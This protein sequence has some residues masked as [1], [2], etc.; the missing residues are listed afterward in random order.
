MFPGEY[1]SNLTRKTFVQVPVISGY[2]T[3]RLQAQDYFPAPISGTLTSM[4]VTLE[5]TGR[6]QTSVLLRETSDRSISGTRYTVMPAVT[7]VPGGK[8]FHFVSKG[9]LSYLELYCSGSDSTTGQSFSDVR[10]QIDSLRRWTEMGF[11]KND[12][13]YPPQLFQAKE[14]PGPLT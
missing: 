12:P 5:N 3:A 7:L 2:V 1:I 4:M 13:F 14:V 9:Y 11:D 8:T 10:M 6:N